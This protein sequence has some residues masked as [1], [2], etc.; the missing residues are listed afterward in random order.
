MCGVAYNHA[1]IDSHNKV[2]PWIDR[3]L[4]VGVAQHLEPKQALLLLRT[5]IFTVETG[6]EAIEGVEHVRF[7]G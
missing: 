7:R 1:P 3:K 2:E 5:R 6:Y 4:L